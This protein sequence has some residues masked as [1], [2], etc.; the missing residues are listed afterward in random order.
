[1]HQNNSFFNVYP[2]FNAL[3][4]G[5]LIL[6]ANQRLASRIRSAYAIACGQRGQKSVVAPAVFSLNNWLDR[7]WLSLLQAANP[8][9]VNHRLL[10]TN[11]ELVIWEDIISGSDLGAALLRPAATA[12][13]AANAYRMLVQ[14]R[15]SIDEPSLTNLFD[16]NEDTRAFADWYNQF[17][18][19]CS[20]HHWLADCRKAEILEQAFSSGALPSPGGILGI[21]FEQLSPLYE[22]LLNV[23][24]QFDFYSLPGLTATV[25]ALECVSPDQ[26]LIASAIWAKNILKN[27]AEARVAIVIPELVQHRN[28]V[29]RVL[30][31]VFE[32]DY[33]MSFLH[34]SEDQPQRGLPF[35]ISAGYPLIDAPVIKAALNALSLGFKVID[36]EVLV[37]ICQSPF[38]CIRDDDCDAVSQ[39]ITELC[40]EQVFAISAAKFRKIVTRSSAPYYEE[41]G[42][43]FSDAL[44]QQAA[45]YREVNRGGEKP[46]SEWSA[47][48]S[49]F[50][51]I[52]GWPGNRRLD[53][54][55]YQQVMQWQL[56]LEE[57]SHL[58]MVL[59]PMGLSE[60]V[61]HL[62]SLLSR[63]IFHQQTAESS[64]QIL[65]T[66]EA[67]GLE[68][69]HLWLQSMSRQMWPA[70][71]APNPLLPLQLQQQYQM[72]HATAERELEYSVQLT[73]RF[74]SSAKEMIVSTPGVVDDNAAPISPLFDN[75]PVIQ[76]DELLGKSF[77]GLQPAYEI[78]RRYFDS[79]KL[80]TIGVTNAPEVTGDEKITGGS[81]LFASQSACPFRAF[82]K[83]RL[84]VRALA[85]PEFGLNPAER[86][87]M[88][89][90][91]LEL[92]WQKLKSQERLLMLADDVVESLCGEISQYVVTE[93]G[94]KKQSKFGPKYQS[95]EADR[96]KKLLISWL[97][98]EKNRASF[99]V[100]NIESLHVFRCEPLELK[101]RI[102]RIDR[103]E[104][105]TLLI[106]D[107]KTGKPSINN[108]WGARPDEPQLPLYNTLID[109]AE[110]V[111]GG[112]A[113]AQVRLEDPKIKGIG[114]EKSTEQI[115]K[116]TDKLM[117]DAGARDWRQLKQMWSE[118]LDKLAKEFIAGRAD[119][120]PK[121]PT[122]TCQYCE[123]D[124]VCRIN[125][126]IR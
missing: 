70:S 14:W 115:I 85:V 15:L 18:N 53:T 103:M 20:S 108:W 112:I 90:R 9:V 114:D 36:L 29:E 119:V 21:G 7:C 54:I 51:V 113:Y 28:R 2:I 86:G 6:T 124:S 10:S 72:P 16:T 38:Y 34:K 121:N 84:G 65:G 60:A 52:L 62:R 107:Y 80:E 30:M 118:V 47:L 109:D 73:K 89:H 98:V 92:L 5:Q 117:A 102:D 31:E 46:T 26:E 24:G 82:V 33:N 116:W 78:R 45:L 44:Q 3:A 95:L 120:D 77:H 83:H 59:K 67:A 106:I 32:P 122:N 94:Q 101:T 64:L 110:N 123:Y 19:R 87:S 91:A 63:H 74:V 96:L 49:E 17:E 41:K 25:S 13:Q 111:V 43:E 39:V 56:V 76:L 57:F 97:D 125:M 61:G 71:P 11:Q 1:M 55:E 37:A 88:L 104:D 40:G 99:V 48:F 75:Y 42:W 105:G 35:N 50:I 58:E 100:E 27:N 66:L 68:F 126:G 4:N 69:S 79:Q 8:I 23:A 12:Q 93:F 22:G 81:A